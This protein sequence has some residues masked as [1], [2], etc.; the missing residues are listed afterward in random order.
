M[1]KLRYYFFIITVFI[2]HC[3][4]KLL[5]RNNSRL[6]YKWH[7]GDFFWKVLWTHELKCPLCNSVDKSKVISF[8]CNHLF[9]VQ[10]M[11]FKNEARCGECPV[12]DLKR[13]KGKK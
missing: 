9:C 4:A 13:N 8:H 7:V 12:C 10:C 6:Y 5:S 11:S 2:E 3:I 1:K